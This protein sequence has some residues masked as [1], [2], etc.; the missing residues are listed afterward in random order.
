M[1]G[2]EKVRESSII[3]NQQE[4]GTST[5]YKHVDGKTLNAYA[6]LHIQDGPEATLEE[7]YSSVAQILFEHHEL[8][9]EENFHQRLLILW[10][11]SNINPG[12]YF[13][14]EEGEKAWYRTS[15]HETAKDNL[16]QAFRLLFE[17]V[18]PN[19]FIILLSNDENSNVI[20]NLIGA[21]AKKGEDNLTIR[22]KAVKSA[23]EV[24]EKIKSFLPDNA[25]AFSLTD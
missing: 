14:I 24:Q 22:Y 9:I 17:N 10:D 21:I 2:W 4:V 20:F 13:N 12:V 8:K 16:I 15:K 7:G 11:L 3:A 19:V 6:L 1:Q 23:E 5:V 18:R 25:P